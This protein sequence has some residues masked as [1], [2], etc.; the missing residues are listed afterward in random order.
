MDKE[1]HSTNSNEETLP[2][3]TRDRPA[4]FELSIGQ[5]GQHSHI[6]TQ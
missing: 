5:H 6:L 3:L 1:L 2:T 4:T